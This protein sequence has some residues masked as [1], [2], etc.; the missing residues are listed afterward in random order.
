MFIEGCLEK[1]KSSLRNDM[2]SPFAAPTELH[3]EGALDAID[4]LRLWRSKASKLTHAQTFESATAP[5]PS[6]QAIYPPLRN[7]FARGSASIKGLETLE[8]T[9]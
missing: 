4:R 8:Y 2:S 6:D 7:A 9:I 5:P 1:E 3:F